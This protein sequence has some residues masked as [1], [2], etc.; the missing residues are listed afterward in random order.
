MAFIQNIKSV[1]VIVACIGIILVG[2]GIVS[3]SQ[4]ASAQ[5]NITAAAFNPPDPTITTIW[6]D[7]FTKSP[8]FGLEANDGLLVIDVLYESDKTVALKSHYSDA[9]WEAVDYVKSN[10]YE[11]DNFAMAEGDVWVVLSKY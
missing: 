9:I 3:F 10:G 2:I 8:K 1:S 7:F 4:S 6:D 5:Q 11:I